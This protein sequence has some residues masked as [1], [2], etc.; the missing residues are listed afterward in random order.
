MNSQI[1]TVG[2]VVELGTTNTPTHLSISAQ[3]FAEMIDGTRLRVTRGAMGASMPRAPREGVAAI[4][5]RYSGPPLPD[6]PADRDRALE[7]YRVTRRD[8]EDAIN[9]LLGRDPEQHRLPASR[10][11][12]S[13]SCSRATGSPS[14]TTTSSRRRLRSSSPS[15]SWQNSATDARRRRPESRCPRFRTAQPP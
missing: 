1:A 8:V 3:L 7:S 4:W 9:Q 10:G 15:S 11:S 12:H 14:P 13:S 2:A 6:D 5:K